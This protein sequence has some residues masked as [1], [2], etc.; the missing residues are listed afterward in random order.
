MLM[1]GSGAWLNVKLFN[2]VNIDEVPFN[3]SIK[4]DSDR[5]LIVI[6]LY[7]PYYINH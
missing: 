4:S 6:T 7:G 2:K 5:S 3:I 1:F